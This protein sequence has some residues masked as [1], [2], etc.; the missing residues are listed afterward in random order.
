MASKHTAADEDFLDGF[1]RRQ[2]NDFRDYMFAPAYIDANSDLFRG[3]DWIDVPAL[4]FFDRNASDAGS[5]TRPPGSSDLVCVKT[6]APAY[7]GLSISMVSVKSEPQST[8]LPRQPSGS[9]NEVIDLV[10]DSEDEA[11]EGS[12]FEVSKE[13]TRS[14]SRSSSIFPLSEDIVFDDT[15]AASRSVI[16]LEDSD[17]ELVESNTLWQDDITSFVC[18]GNFKITQNV[19]NV[20]RIEYISEFASI[21]PIHRD[22]TVIVVDLSDPKF[23]LPNP[24]TG[25]CYTLDHLISDADN[26]SWNNLGSG[27][28]SFTALVTFGP[29]EVDIKC[30]RARYKFRG[31]F[32]CELI[33]S[34]LLDVVRYDLDPASRD[35]VLSAQ[36][37]TRW[38]DGVTPEQNV[39]IF[40]AIIRDAKCFAVDSNGQPCRGA[41]MMKAKPQGQSRGHQYF[42]CCSGWTTKFKENHRTLTIPDYVDENLLVASMADRPLSDTRDKDTKPSA[43]PVGATVSKVDNAPS[44]K[45]IL[46][47]KT[48]GE[49]SAALTSKRVKRHLVHQV[50]AARYPNGLGVTGVFHLYLNNLTKPL[51]ERYIHGYITTPDGGICILT[52]V[53]F[54]LK[55]L[56]D[57]GVIAFDD[58]ATYKRVEGEM[59]Q[60][61]LSIFVKMVLRAASVARAYINR[62]SADFF[63]QVFDEVQRVKLMVTGK[64]IPLKRFVRGG[65]L[66]VMN[67]DM[68]G[69]QAIGICRSVMK[70]N[71]PE[72]SG[73]PNNTPPEK[74]APYFIK[75]CWRHSK[76][77]VHDLKSLVSAPDHARLLDFVYIDSKETL[78]KF[79]AFVA[80]LGIK[81]IQ[82]WWAHKEMNPWIIPCLVKS[83]SLI[84][85]DIWDSTPSTTN[86]NEAQHHWTNVQ[87]G[88][89]L[90]PVE[91]I[92]SAHEVDQ[93][94]ADE[95]QTSMQTG[96][97]T[98][99]HNEVANRMGRSVQ[100]QSAIAKKTRESRAQGEAEKLITEEMAELLQARRESSARTKELKVQLKLVKGKSGRGKSS[101]SS[102]TISASSSGRVKSVAASGKSLSFETSTTRGY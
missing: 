59:N 56:D 28:G 35:T 42:I 26:D 55:L 95:I 5:S 11:G 64:P 92:E 49:Y 27:T 86:T 75:I 51:P 50:K 84:P 23:I 30:R 68:D 29:D 65:N 83:Q 90:T 78:D 97:F 89:K 98:N 43:G 41:P 45:L 99:P 6:E 17:D 39:A 79:S 13:L 47:G 101:A 61:E 3:Y 72:Y 14:A 24:K 1:S 9:L 100:R 48:P 22:S 91:A 81:K 60:W 53:P 66:L 69:A 40:K 54:L 25:E 36:A 82:D 33:D 94:T 31:A 4:E 80:N 19:R 52:C 73:I 87:T 37:D 46:D 18:F 20:Q 2:L 7:S 71:D 44:T 15:D 16:D 63:E 102:T 77:P 67:A 85:A 62:A 38:N 8:A 32:A 70:H 21:Y 96:I 10:S 34:T 88:I 58:D 57:P 74:I 12:D 76:E 93:R